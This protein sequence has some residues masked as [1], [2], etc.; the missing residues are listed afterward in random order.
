MAD[1]VNEIG[2]SKLLGQDSVTIY[3]RPATNVVEDQFVRIPC[4]QCNYSQLIYTRPFCRQI[5]LP[6]AAFQ[7]AHFEEMHANRKYCLHK[8]LEIHSPHLCLES[9]SSVAA[10]EVVQMRF[11]PSARSGILVTL[12]REHHRLLQLSRWGKCRRRHSSRSGT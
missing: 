5:T 9:G 10:T 8:I 12:N 7:A 3:F 2:L 11:S 1:R 4:M 6:I